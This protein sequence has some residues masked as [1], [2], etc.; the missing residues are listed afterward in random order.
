MTEFLE[1]IKL[2]NEEER[3]TLKERISDAAYFRN[4][5]QQAKRLAPD[6]ERITTVGFTATHRD[7]KTTVALHVPVPAIWTPSPS[8]QY[9]IGDGSGC[10]FISVCAVRNRNL[11]AIDRV[12]NAGAKQLRI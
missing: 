2:F 10:S 7:A 3:N 12:N 8:R 6:G 11:A 1:C 9:K 5:V 4:F